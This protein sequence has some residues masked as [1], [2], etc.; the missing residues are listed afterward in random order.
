M[1]TQYLSNELAGD[2]TGTTTSAPVGYK[3][4]ATDYGSRMKRYRAS[5]TLNSQASGDSI[6]LATIPA[7]SV[8]AFG[9]I[10]T[11]TSTSTATL[12]IGT[13]ASAAAF[14]AASAYTTTDSPTL[15]GKAAEE[16]SDPLTA[17]TD[18]IA[19]IGTAALPSSGNLVVDLFFSHPN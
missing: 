1:A 3:P 17:D 19:T 14:A 8:F 6:K 16:V 7:G 10:N 15:F 13:S 12:E 11:D 5:I 4:D 9:L 2:T 18:I